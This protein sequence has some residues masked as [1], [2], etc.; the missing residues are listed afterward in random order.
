MRKIKEV[1]RLKYQAGLSAR[2]IARSCGIARSTV[3]EYLMRARAAGIEW[4]LPAETDD[5]AIEARLF[6]SESATDGEA[7]ERSQPDFAAIRKELQ[8]RKHVTLQLLWQEYKESHPQGYQY[9]QFCD[10]YHRWRKKLDLTL[11][12]TYR[13]GEKLFV[14]Y[15]GQTVPITDSH[16]GAVQ[17]AVLF[18]AVLGASNYTYAEATL[19]ADLESWIGA[20]VRAL[21]FFGGGA[22]IV[23]PDNLKAGVN[24]P[25][26]YEP[27]LNPTY[28]E[29]AAHYGM[30]VIPARVR[31]PR[32]KAKVEGGVLVCER[33]ILAALRKRTFFNIAELNQA[34]TELCEQLNQ[35]PYRKLPGSRWQMFEQIE[36]PALKPLPVE[37]FVF[38]E[39]KWDRVRNDHHVELDG[40]YYSAPS[41]LAGQRVELRFT[42][43]TVEVFHH[44]IR[45]ASHARSLQAGSTTTCDVH[46]P[47]SHRRYLE[48][49]FARLNGWAANCGSATAALVDRVFNRELHPQQAL[50]VGL[51]LVRLG[52][53]Y[54][55]AR[56]EAACGRALRFDACF[57]KSVASILKNGLDHRLQ[58]TD[59]AVGPPLLHDNVRGAGYFDRQEEDHHVN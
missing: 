43:T 49:D 36:R 59:S 12:Q 5:G 48:W 30:A 45:V 26:R 55:A 14:D 7:R 2:Q 27:D 19:H 33:W 35:R 57:Y 58:E 17:P 3:A 31:K 54:G 50:R 25:C 9:S 20:H 32:D 10:L 11:R 40:H 13:A 38:A 23:I 1:L 46:R 29:M 56:L 18:V 47:E 51:G 15:A 28:Q 52:E 21:E 39:W 42:A 16:T 6:A 53:Q 41:H 44:S 24:R 34:I 37:R 4:P 22:E 8:S